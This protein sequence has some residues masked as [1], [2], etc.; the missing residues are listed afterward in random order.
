L[1]FSSPEALPINK[2]LS[3]T[4]K[5]T[6]N[7]KKRQ[8]PVKSTLLFDYLK[9]QCKKHANR[10][11]LFHQKMP[12]AVGISNMNLGPSPQSELEDGR[13][14]RFSPASAISPLVFGFTTYNQTLSLSICATSN[15]YKEEELPYLENQFKHELSLL[16]D[17]SPI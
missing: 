12:I 5:K 11:K 2:L 3:M 10:F 14:F 9:K 15:R 6:H 7:M 4:H 13:Y 1:L 17:S 8:V 16:F